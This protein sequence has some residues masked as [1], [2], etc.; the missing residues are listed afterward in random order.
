[1][2]NIFNPEEVENIHRLITLYSNELVKVKRDLARLDTQQAE[3]DGVSLQLKCIFYVVNFQLLEDVPAEISDQYTNRQTVHLLEVSNLVSR[4][5][6]L[7]SR[8]SEMHF[9]LSLQANNNGQQVI[10]I[11]TNEYYVFNSRL[12]TVASLE[13]E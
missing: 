8:L 10:S 4:Q 9:W 2:E 1:M 7:E 13:L 3:F 6:T 11:V 12:L 5:I